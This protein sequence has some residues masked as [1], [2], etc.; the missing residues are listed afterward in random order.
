MIYIDE[1]HYR[2]YNMNDKLYYYCI[3]ILHQKILVQIEI[4]IYHIYEKS[5]K[6]GCGLDLLKDIFNLKLL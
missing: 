5:D 4:K 1:Q 2:L 3:L 6:Y